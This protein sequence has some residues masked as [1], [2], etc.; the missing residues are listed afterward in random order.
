MIQKC[1]QIVR[2]SKLEMHIDILMVLARHGPLKRTHIM[3]NA[4]VNCRVLE[5]YLDFLITNN[6]VEEK[7]VGKKRVVYAI[8]ERGISVL[9]YFKE[10]RSI[11]P[12]IEQERDQTSTIADESLLASL[13]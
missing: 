6:L 5:E 4:N 12:I 13:D 1:G 2:R 3:Y 11:L 7:V 8:T 9:K 10:I